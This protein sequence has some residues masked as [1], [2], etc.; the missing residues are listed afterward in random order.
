M[1]G[2]PNLPQIQGS[3]VTVATSFIK[4]KMLRKVKVDGKR[5]PFLMMSREKKHIIVV[6]WR[7]ILNKYSNPFYKIYYILKLFWR[8]IQ[9]SPFLRFCHLFNLRFFMWLTNKQH[10][11]CISKLKSVMHFEKKYVEVYKKS[12]EKHGWK[13]NLYF[14]YASFIRFQFFLI[15]QKWSK[16]REVGHDFLQTQL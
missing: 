11:T 14:K 3:H 7:H 2:S 6:R 1:L 16:Y 5:S 9:M 13:S 12:D 15:E 4:S 8:E 10:Y